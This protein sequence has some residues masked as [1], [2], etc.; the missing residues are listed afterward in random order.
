LQLELLGASHQTF[1]KLETSKAWK[2]RTLHVTRLL[3]SLSLDD[4]GLASTNVYER[5]FEALDPKNRVIP[6]FDGTSR[7]LMQPKIFAR[8]ASRR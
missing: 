7:E 6:G 2:A 5:C 4:S 3:K 1:K 8:K